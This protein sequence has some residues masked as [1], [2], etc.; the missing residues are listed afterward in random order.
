MLLACHQNAG[1]NRDV[2]AANGSFENA[3]QFKYL[4]MTIRN[5]NLIQ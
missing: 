3:S 2:N 4:G 5:K 1:Q